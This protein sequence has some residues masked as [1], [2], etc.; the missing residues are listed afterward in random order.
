[1]KVPVH[2]IGP[3]GESLP[4]SQAPE[5]RYPPVL[6]RVIVTV[7]PVP[8][9]I[10]AD[11]VWIVPTAFCVGA[12]IDKGDQVSAFPHFPSFQPMGKN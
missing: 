1:M 7:E 6:G 12:M 9:G 5:A 4:A 10:L 3:Y 8:P 2:E 11:P